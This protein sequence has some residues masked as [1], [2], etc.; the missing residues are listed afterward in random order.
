VWD[1]LPPVTL[2]REALL[3]MFEVR[4]ARRKKSSTKAG[5][6]QKLLVLDFKRSN[7]IC[8]AMKRLPALR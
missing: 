3:G 2:D 6:L 4:E 5:K 7:T 1:S 8:I